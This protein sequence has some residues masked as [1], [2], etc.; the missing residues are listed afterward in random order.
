MRRGPF[1]RKQMGL[2]WPELAAGLGD[3][4]ALAWEHL[5]TPKVV[6]LHDP[7]DHDCGVSIWEVFGGNI[8]DV[9]IFWHDHLFGSFSLAV[10]AWTRSECYSPGTIAYEG[11]DAEE[12]D[13]GEEIFPDVLCNT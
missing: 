6:H 2:L 12:C 13:A 4:Q 8:P 1:A 10:Y 5:R 7:V 11:D 9:A 3:V